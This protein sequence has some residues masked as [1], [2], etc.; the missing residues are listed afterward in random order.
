[1]PRTPQFGE[2]YEWTKG[3]SGLFVM[4]IC[5]TTTGAFVGH[6]TGVSVKDTIPYEFS[7]SWVP[8]GL[9]N[10]EMGWVL[11]ERP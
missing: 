9:L 7:G 10:D 4:F 11:A 8:D 5:H 1:M 3:P 2:V 6:W